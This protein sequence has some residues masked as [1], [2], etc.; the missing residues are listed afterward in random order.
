MTTTTWVGFNP[1]AALAALIVLALS[2]CG[3]GGT[4]G[5][6]TPSQQPQSITTEI[7][8]AANASVNTPLGRLHNN[9]WNQQAAGNQ[10]W[11]QCLL[12]QDTGE[13]RLYG[14]SWQWPADTKQVLAYP[15]LTVGAKPWEPGPGNDARFPRALAATQKLLLAYDLE[16][17]STG[18]NNLAASMWLINTPTVANPPD[19]AAITT[20]V[21][22]WTRT[23]GADWSAG[24]T[25]VAEVSIDD[26]RWQVFAQRNWG[27]ASGGSSHRWTL[28]SYLAMSASNRASIDLRKILADAQARGLVS[29]NDYIANVELGNEVANGTGTTWVK[30]FSVTIE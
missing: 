8:C 5:D 18:D 1:S 17:T 10:R 3:G 25:P 24:D 30:A 4:P 23:D 15:G 14:W 9:A 2:A 27:D 29:G 21:M 16:T 28:V 7:D 22:V 11:R 26:Q 20:E 19:E 12:R 13:Q 6:A